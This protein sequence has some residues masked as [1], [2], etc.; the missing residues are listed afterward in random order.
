[1]KANVHIAKNQIEAIKGGGPFH[2]HE[3]RLTIGLIVKNEEK[4]LDKCLSSLSPLLNAVPSELIITDTGSTDRTVEVAQKYTDHII[5]FE[6]C[7]DFSA[8]RNTGLDAARG[9]WFLYLDGDE[10]FDDVTEL[11]DFFNSGECDRYGSAA[12]IQ[13]NYKDLLGENQSDDYVCRVF[14]IYPD[15]QFRNKIHEDFLLPPPTKILDTFVHHYGYVF[16]SVEEAESKKNRN[17]VLL[18]KEL[19]ADP[20]DIKA[21][22]QL[23]GQLIGEDDEQ[24]EIYAKR[25]LE[26]AYSKKKDLEPH[27]CIRM[28]RALIDAYFDDK[29]YDEV[30]KLIPEVL[31]DETGQGVFHLEFYRIGQMAAY[32]LKQ[33]ET[34]VEYGNLYLGLY[35]AYERKEMDISGLIFGYFNFLTPQSR[36]DCLV[37]NGKAFLKL[38]KPEEAQKCL[39]S[40]EL[41]LPNSTRD[42]SLPLCFSI[43]DKLGNWS[44]TVKFYGR[45]LLLGDDGKICDFIEYANGYCAIY[46]SKREAVMRAFADTEGENA[47]YL[48]CRLR[49][50]EDADDRKQSTMLLESLCRSDGSW[51]AG[52]ADILW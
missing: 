51:G 12:Y 29:R 22:F 7:D 21:L 30:L 43:A 27:T 1:M 4:T 8:A 3:L 19:E 34:A 45:M 10:W 18:E 37:M 23:S 50:A 33:Y 5:H 13:R 44:L 40:L 39:D 52:Y 14:R 26:A 20:T 11:V 32:Q 31:E 24:A 35:P 41:S 47:W 25:G 28:A 6:W 42:G 46:P 2:G 38:K 9:E 16:R 36:E 49:L 17:R 48:L 15:S